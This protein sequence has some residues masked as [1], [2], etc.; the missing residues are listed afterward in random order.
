MAL[1]IPNTID[2][3]IAANGAHL[4]GNFGAI[5]T[6]VDDLETDLTALEGLVDERVNPSVVLERTTDVG[7]S[8]SEY[9]VVWET[10]TLTNLSSWWTSGTVLTVPA[11][12]GGVYIVNYVGASSFA[13]GTYGQKGALRFRSTTNEEHVVTN[14]PSSVVS[15]DPYTTGTVTTSHSSVI[16]LRAGQTFHLHRGSTL[17]NSTLENVKLTLIKVA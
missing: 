5:K 6:F 17:E 15:G 9:I 8:T 1:T 7:P 16:T 14:Y 2:N 12:E 13:T 10:E 4:A 3:T 11:G